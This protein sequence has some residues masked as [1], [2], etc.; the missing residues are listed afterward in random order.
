MNNF[1]KETL[2][3]L[4]QF[5]EKVHIWQEALLLSFADFRPF[6][7]VNITN[8]KLLV[9]SHPEER[10]VCLIII[11]SLAIDGCLIREVK[12]YSDFAA[13]Q[14]NNELQQ[15]ILWVFGSSYSLNISI[16]WYPSTVCCTVKSN[17]TE[18][19]LLWYDTMCA[20]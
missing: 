19:N 2:T 17:W 11:P 18:W 4:N 16:R 8:D 6:R 5:L 15:L 14:Y 20:S 10:K 13:Q 9:T 1:K 12:P 3:L 7:I